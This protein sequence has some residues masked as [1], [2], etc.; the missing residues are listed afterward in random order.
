[1]AKICRICNRPIKKKDL[2]RHSPL[3]HHLPPYVDLHLKC[4]KKLHSTINWRYSKE[5]IKMIRENGLI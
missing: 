1:M 5:N 3:S 2:S 4:H